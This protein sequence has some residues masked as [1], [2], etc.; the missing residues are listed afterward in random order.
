LPAHVA[1]GQAS[2]RTSARGRD[3]PCKEVR[4]DVR[5]WRASARRPGYHLRVTTDPDTCYRALAARDPRFDGV[6]FVGVATTGVYCRPVCTARTPRLDR[7]AFFTTSAAAER[8][9]Y[10]ACFRC[11]PE[12]APGAAPIDAVPRLVAAAIARI[13]EGYLNEASVDDLAAE[14]GVAGR[15]LRRVVGAV[16][17]VSPA[18]LAHTRRLALAKQLLHD[19]DL[20]VTR[21]ALTAGFGSLRRFNA[22]FRAAFGAPPSRLRRGAPPRERGLLLRLGYRPPLDWRRLLAFLAGRAVPGVEAIDVAAGSYRRDGLV[23]RDDPARACL[24]VEVAPHLAGRAMAVSARLRALFDL[25]AHPEAIAGALGRDRRLGPAVR[26]RPGL[27]IPG[28]YDPLEVAVR[29]VLGQ[30]VAVR[31]ATTLMARITAAIPD[32]AAAR[33]DDVAALGIPGRRAAAVVALAR[34]VADGAI[35]LGRG[36]DPVATTAA[37]EA[38]PGIGPWTAHYVVMRAVGW[39]DAFVAGDLVVRRALGGVTAAEASRIADAWRPWRAY[40][41]LHLWTASSEGDPPCT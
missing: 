17:G 20:P 3:E 2:R 25:D 15:H 21:I 29:A 8:A 10:R 5:I 4:F 24:R 41:V 1:V 36:V 26:A 35:R 22:A 14:L 32:L 38:I 6:F 9:G 23:V 39:P 40:A 19:T 27:R 31:A 28:A 18:E 7:C 37:L 34:A 33:V 11:R 13:D 12:L 16:L 30:Q